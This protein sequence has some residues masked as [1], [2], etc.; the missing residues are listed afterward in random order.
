MQNTVYVFRIVTSEGL[1]AYEEVV[2]G[3]REDAE[4][5]L[6]QFYGGVKSAEFVGVECRPG[7]A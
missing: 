6:L 2:A 4:R 5:G 3:S 7:T 1:T